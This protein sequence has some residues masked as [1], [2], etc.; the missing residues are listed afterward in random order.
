MQMFSTALI[1]FSPCWAEDSPF[2]W[3]SFWSTKGSNAVCV[4]ALRAASSARFELIGAMKTVAKEK[5]KL[6]L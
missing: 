5:V 4:A 2:R 3:S 6:E 1:V